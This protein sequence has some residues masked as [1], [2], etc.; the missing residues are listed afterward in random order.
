MNILCLY[1]EIK[2][3]KVNIMLREKH[4]PDDFYK[5]G[6]E[7]ILFSPAACDFGG[8]CIT[9]LEKDFN[10]FDKE[11]L[12]NIF[13]EISLSKIKFHTINKEL[14]SNTL[15]QVRLFFAHQVAEELHILGFRI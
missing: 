13:N 14:K 5:K 3:W 15:I 4:R 9:P 6:E 2:G 11:L 7:R 10:R 12:N 8:L 1:E